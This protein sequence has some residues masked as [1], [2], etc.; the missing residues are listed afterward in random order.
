[1]HSAYH[2]RMVHGAYYGYMTMPVETSDCGNKRKEF[3]LYIRPRRLYPVYI[4]GDG[5]LFILHGRGGRSL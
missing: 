1:M 4:P 3:V 2:G 5:A